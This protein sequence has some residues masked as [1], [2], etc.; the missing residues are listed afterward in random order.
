MTTVAFINIGKPIK[1]I[2]VLDTASATKTIDLEFS[3]TMTLELNE[4]KMKE[5]IYVDCRANLKTAKCTV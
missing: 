4:R 2:C 3:E 1:I 5:F